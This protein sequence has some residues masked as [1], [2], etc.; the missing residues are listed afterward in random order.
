[1]NGRRGK[2]AGAAGRGLGGLIALIGLLLLPGAAAGA[3]HTG[4]SEGS[5]DGSLAAH[6][7]VLG[8]DARYD[9]AGKLAVE[10]RLRGAAPAGA[11]DLVGAMLGS[12]RAGGSCAAPTALVLANF[13]GEAVWDMGDDAG[14]AQVAV[15][16]ERVTLR[17]SDPR[18]AKRQLRCATAFVAVDPDPGAS[19]DEQIVDVLDA[20]AELTAPPVLEPRLKVELSGAHRVKPGG[21][22]RIKAR[23]SNVGRARAAAVRVRAKAG[24]GVGLRPS[25]ARWGS[26]APGKSRTVALRAKVAKGAR[27]TVAVSVRATGRPR[28]S[29][30][31][32]TKLKVIRPRPRHAPVSSKGGLA[33]TYFWRTVTHVNRAWDNRGLA[34]VDGRWA[35]RGFPDA[36]LPRCRRVTAKDEA[37]DGCLRYSYDPRTR[38]L[39]VGGQTGR[40]GRGGITLDG[41][42]YGELAIPKPGSRFKVSLIHRSFEGMCGM[43]S[44]C[45]T[46]ATYLTMTRK[47]Q[48]ALSSQSLGTMGGGG[49]PFTAAWTAPPDEY[50]RYEIGRRGRITLFYADGHKERDTIGIQLDRRL[51]P[52]PAKEG[53]LLG[54]RNF[55][56]E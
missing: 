55:Y 56:V 35:Y 29:A 30:G 46:S 9:D 34:F 40:Y 25:G 13:A 22:V 18:L 51:R 33:G 1:M 52:S 2:L 26:I 5:A 32:R 42:V 38:K 47:G 15:K 17:A 36:G 43:P 41:D 12:A 49:V 48:F 20:P 21:T 23:V 28:L 19:G 31:A 50:G 44:G 10:V 27:G 45:W 14:D 3:V 11:T 37:D 54:S 7:D 8:I 4:Q 39:R 53:L 16:G 24:R 6:R